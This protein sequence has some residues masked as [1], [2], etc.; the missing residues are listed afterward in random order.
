MFKKNIHIFEMRAREKEKE[1]EKKDWVA[2]LYQVS[3]KLKLGKKVV[4]Y[5][6]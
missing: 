5:L 2:K 4:Y 3:C 6:L 1:R